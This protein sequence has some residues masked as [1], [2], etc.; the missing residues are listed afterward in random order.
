MPDETKHDPAMCL[1][2]REI[3]ARIGDKWT[4]VVLGTLAMK[5]LRFK[6]LHRAVGN[7]SQRM[8][9]VTLRNLERDG[10]MVR[11]VYPTV[12]PRVDY[13]LSP[14]GVSLLQTLRPIGGWVIE[15]QA[16]IEAA[17]ERYD[18]EA[19]AQA[20]PGTEEELELPLPGKP[21]PSALLTKT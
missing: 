15:N 3:F 7:I 4:L 12:P 8:L 9:V 2:V 21:A 6:D 11:H 13:E 10:L 16:S 14:R 1:P 17:R 5:R 19:E 20:E 18:R